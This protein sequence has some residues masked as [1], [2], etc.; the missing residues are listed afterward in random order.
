[1]ARA[2]WYKSS[3]KHCNPALVSF[4]HSTHN[5]VVMRVSRWSFYWRTA[6]TSMRQDEVGLERRFTCSADMVIATAQPL[7]KLVGLNDFDLCRWDDAHLRRCAL[8]K[9][10]DGELPARERGEHW[11][12]ERRYLVS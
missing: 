6:H 9:R 10:L 8:G 11:C 7:L 1:M 2:P 4:I 12:S 5:D 3:P